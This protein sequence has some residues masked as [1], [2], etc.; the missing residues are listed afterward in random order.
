MAEQLLKSYPTLGCCGL[1]CGLCPRY[2]TVGESKC[3]GCC[4][5]GFTD[6]HPTCPFVT[7]CVKKKKLEVCAACDEFPCARTEDS[8]NVYDS[9]VTHRKTLPNLLDIRQHG[10]NKFIE[11]QQKRIYLLE[12][13]LSQ[14][15][16]GRSKSFYCIAAALL[17]IPVLEEAMNLAEQQVRKRNIGVD[18]IK[19]KAALL[20][21]I[22]GELAN[23]QGVELKLRKKGE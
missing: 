10:L 14:F 5:P 7:C 21:E 18:D 22:L 8:E 1:D 11:E 3:P 16:D 23:Q 13:M 20:K 12:T 15:D 19:T 6:K 17:P 9:F 2:Y 4:G